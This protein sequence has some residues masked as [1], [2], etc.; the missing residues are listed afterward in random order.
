MLRVIGK[1]PSNYP[2]ASTCILT[3]VCTYYETHAQ[4]TVYTQENTHM[5]KT[6]LVVHIYCN[7]SKTCFKSRK[8]FLVFL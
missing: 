7:K 2:L 3:Q 8:P 4:T 5:Y 6:L 1:T